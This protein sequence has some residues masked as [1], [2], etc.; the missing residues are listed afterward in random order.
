MHQT[1]QDVSIEEIEAKILDIN[2]TEV[3]QRLVELG[4]E[5]VFDGRLEAV[6]FDYPDHRLAAQGSYLR[7]RREGER[8][9]LVGKLRREGSGVKVR[10][11]IAVGVDDFAGCA[12]LLA[13]IGLE[14]VNRVSK[15]RRSWQLGGVRCEFD[16]YEGE[17]AFIPEFLEIE[18]E[19]AAA[20]RETA[21]RLGFTP[22]CL[23]PWGLEELIKHYQSRGA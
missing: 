6:F 19:S 22:E 14:I 16:R 15:W 23:R 4:A 8:I 13:A 12:A 5:M 7:L 17:L 2:R 18:A 20:V 9:E 3:E 10:E 11:E 1:G 21:G